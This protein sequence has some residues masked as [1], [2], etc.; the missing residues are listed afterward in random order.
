MSRADHQHTKAMPG[1]VKKLKM[2]DSDATEVSE[3]DTDLLNELAERAL[4]RLCLCLGLLTNLLL[5]M[6][7]FGN[8]LL[9]TCELHTIS[10]LHGI[11]NGC[12]AVS[13]I[14]ALLPK[15]CTSSSLCPHKMSTSLEILFQVYSRHRPAKGA[16]D[17]VDVTSPNPDIYFLLGHLSILF[18]MLL[19]S[20][21]GKRDLILDDLPL[22]GD[23][24]GK[25]EQLI[26]QAG[27]F[28]AFYDQFGGTEDQKV[29]KEVITFLQNFP[30]SV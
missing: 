26:D 10:K 1:I 30:T 5:D 20:C 21:P 3:E 29:T 17:P 2:E 22:E 7:D 28:S 25:L 24:Q 4:D 14:C 6:D 23:H 12:P 27:I 15:P 11:L 18:G 9:S 19:R 13:Q 8:V 16:L